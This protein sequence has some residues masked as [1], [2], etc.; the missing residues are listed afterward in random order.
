MAASQQC[1]AVQWRLFAYAFIC[2]HCL[3]KDKNVNAVAEL[4]KQDY[5]GD[6]S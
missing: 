3:N 1:Q 5:G 4:P 2:Q 6:R